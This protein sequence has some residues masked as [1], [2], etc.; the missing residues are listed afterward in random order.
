MELNEVQAGNPFKFNNEGVIELLQVEYSG[1]AS[2]KSGEKLN[3]SHSQIQQTT[4]FPYIQSFWSKL[5][6]QGKAPGLSGFP[7]SLN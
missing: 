1:C 6:L 3:L 4:G 7:I 2:I 5:R